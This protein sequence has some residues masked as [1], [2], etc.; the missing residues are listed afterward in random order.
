MLSLS[1]L[2][3]LSSVGVSDNNFEPEFSIFPNPAKTN[4]HIESNNGEIIREVNVYNN[5]GQNVINEKG[6]I[7]QIDISKLGDGMYIIEVISIDLKTRQLLM[8][9]Q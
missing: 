1:G 2:S 9:E 8:I 3:N 4:L 7:T 5:I 6:R